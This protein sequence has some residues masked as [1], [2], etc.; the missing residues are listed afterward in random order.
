MVKEVYNV[1]NYTFPTMA[2]VDVEREETNITATIGINMG[3]LKRLFERVKENEHNLLLSSNSICLTFRC[4]ILTPISYQ[5]S[6]M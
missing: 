2:T 1:F 3:L 5:L 4:L 6:D